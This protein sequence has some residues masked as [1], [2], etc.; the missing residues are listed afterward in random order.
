MPLT[1]FALLWKILKTWHFWETVIVTFVSTAH[2][3]AERLFISS[4]V[5]LAHSKDA[6]LDLLFSFILLKK[7]IVGRT[8]NL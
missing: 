5:Y 4:S 7:K 1:N 2:R 8:L 6:N 3:Y